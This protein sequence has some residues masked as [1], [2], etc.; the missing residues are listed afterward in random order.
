MDV[1]SGLCAALLLA[2]AA[3]ATSAQQAKP[4]DVAVGPVTLQIV[5]TDS[6]EKELRHGQ[7]VLVKDY[8]VNEGLAAK[9]KDTHARVFDVGPG[10][11]ACDGWPAVVTVDK[12]GK[13]AIDTTMKGLCAFFVGLRRRGRLHLRRARRA[14]S[15]WLG[16]A[17]RAGRRV[18]GGSVCWCS[19]RSRTAPGTIS[20]RRSNIRWRCL[21]LRRSMLRCAS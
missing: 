2:F 19:G 14:G 9:L 21:I 20:T 13:V 18:C 17:L 3:Q 11:N 10:G 4:Q 5:E 1:R 8:L 6:G 7:R 16:V 15:G 12:D